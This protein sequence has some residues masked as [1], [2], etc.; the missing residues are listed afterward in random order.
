[1]KIIKCVF[2]VLLLA[3]WGCDNLSFKK[4]PQPIER[5]PV[6]E[7]QREDPEAAEL[8][9]KF[10]PFYIYDDKGSRKNHYIP[11][12][13][14]PNG[15]CLRFNDRVSE[16]CHSGDSCVRIIY[17]VK[18]SLD[19]QNWAGIYWLNPPNNWGKIKGGFDLTGATRLTF[20]AKGE[21]G[22]ERIEEF[23]VGGIEGDYPDSDMAWIGP[24]ILTDQ[25]R[26][27]IIDLR[28]K[29]I[30]YISGGFSWSTNVNANPESCTFY[31]DNMK[32]E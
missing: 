14:M 8:K 5:T 26:E 16:N 31:L 13:F 25:W 7:L 15:K 2:I 4:N 10:H 29:D 1:M 11:S 12:G 32:F 23:R 22:G 24:V 30:S 20:W 17:D 6:L 9:D 3:F 28:G 21:N 27:Y 19:D 18:C